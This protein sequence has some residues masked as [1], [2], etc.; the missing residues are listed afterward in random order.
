VDDDIESSRSDVLEGVGE[1]A[2]RG[3]VLRFLDRIFCVMRVWEKGR[4]WAAKG[5]E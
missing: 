1:L 3:E 5:L 4:A 2:R